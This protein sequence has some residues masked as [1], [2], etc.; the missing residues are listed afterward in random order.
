M[1]EMHTSLSESYEIEHRN[2]KFNRSKIGCIASII[3]IPL[4]ANL[5]HIVYPDFAEQFFSIRLFCELFLIFIFALHYAAPMK[6]YL[7]LLTFAWPTGINVS[8]CAMIYLSDGAV[9]PYYAG[10]NLVLIGA[11][12][13]LPF[14]VIESFLL[15]LITLA[16][17]IYTSAISGTIQNDY[18]IFYNN[19]SF[20]ILT[21]VV[22]CIVSHFNTRSR[23]KE[24]QLSHDLNIRNQQLIDLEKLRTNFFANISHELRTPLT[25]ILSPV[26]DLLN[27]DADLSPRVRK[28]L[29]I[30]HRNALRLLKLV[31]DLLEVIRIEEGKSQLDLKPLFVDAFL[32]EL[33]DSISYL[34]SK[35][36]ILIEKR[37]ICPSVQIR[38]DMY[39]FEKII[40]NLLHNAIKFSGPGSLITLSTLH[41]NNSIHITI[42]DTGYG[43]R[44]EEL[45][46][47]FDR[48]RQADSSSTRQY[49]GS[50]LGLSL[51]KDLSEQLD[52]EIAVS[53]KFGSG[54][55]FTL[56]FP[57]HR[58]A[59]ETAQVVND[60]NPEQDSLQKLYRLANRSG[61][62]HLESSFPA[63]IHQP[64]AQPSV[65]SPH[66]LLIVEDEHD[67][68]EYLVAALQDSYSILQAEDG[69]QAYRII[70]EQK[71][72][73]VLLDLMIPKIDGLDL[74]ARIKQD[75][76]CRGIKIILLTARIDED[77]KITALNNGA[78]DFLTKPFSTLELQT[79]IRNLLKS[80]DFEQQLT[81][82]NREL[83]QTLHELKETQAQLI[84][85]EKTNALEYLS[86]GIL[87]E[88]NNPLNYTLTAL[89]LA[90][91]LPAANHDDMLQEIF[92]DMNEGM[93]RIK[94]IVSDLQTFAHPSPVNK[95]SSFK[96]S[97]A[98]KT[99]LNFTSQDVS[100]A[101]I[102]N[103]TDLDLQVIGSKN[104]IVQVLINLITNALKAVRAVETQR[105]GDILITTSVKGGR[106]L[107][108]VRDN[109]TGIDQAILDKIFD[110][111]FT[112][113]DVGEG[114]GLGLSVSQTIIK[115]H[116]GQLRAT[117]AH[118]EWTE[119]SFDLELGHTGKL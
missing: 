67:L 78:D 108:T 117:S 3:M 29:H 93:C 85:S 64:V 4:G 100:A 86:A 12:F 119:F 83:K 88:I 17:Y 47:I 102:R 46:F 84:Q 25:L 35:K 56:T 11:T 99:A 42:A 118:G 5:D 109:G 22:I 76:S 66:T 20:L 18:R 28:I 23:F 33:A 90:R 63:S 36:K 51:V 113:R 73:L 89:Q 80:A 95:Q 70:L 111:F 16:I 98:L 103:Q 82:T 53:S 55:T 75:V 48:F 87:H 9:S 45:P 27:S 40:I 101:V 114:M 2:Q 52:G 7:S 38:C 112:T 44:M 107:V 32:N 30:S 115:A 77:A 57:V 21:G 110:P 61:M 10:L 69:E 65:R 71:P 94:D 6:K 104:H 1:K 97:Q 60:P 49:Q 92:E 96:F 59:P 58:F 105:K 54:T 50:G 116:S 34:S 39:A 37:L 8:T 24:F 15:F 72:S 74:C 43:I 26:Q 81:G 68:R 19:V 31:N 41:E 91:G 79:R 14:K 106:L 62:L 13:L